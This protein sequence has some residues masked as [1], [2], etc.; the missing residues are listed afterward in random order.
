[1]YIKIVNDTPEI[2][3]IQQLRK[4]NPNVSFPTHI[5]NDLLAEFDVYPL[6]EKSKPSCDYSISTLQPSEIYNEDGVW[7]RH[8][9]VVN[10]PLA[11]ASANCK[12]IRDQLLSETDWV[13]TKAVETGTP[14]PDEYLHYRQELRDLPSYANFPYNIVWPAKPQSQ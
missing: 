1:M 13:V 2:Y 9:N 14:V 7:T 6:V 4:D 10:L 12:A 3:T 11:D 5:T 8:Y